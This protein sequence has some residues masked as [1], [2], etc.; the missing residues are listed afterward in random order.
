MDGSCTPEK[1]AVGR[2]K[3]LQNVS[4]IIA[5]MAPRITENPQNSLTL[6]RKRFYFYA[7]VEWMKVK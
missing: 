4:K 2:A 3:G 7:P 6:N 5:L 1:E